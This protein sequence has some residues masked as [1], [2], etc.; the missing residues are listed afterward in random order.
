M[1]PV[2]LEEAVIVNP[3][4]RDDVADGIASA[5]TMSQ[6]ERRDRHA[7]M[8]DVLRKNDITAWRRRF[9]GALAGD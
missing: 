3:H 5:L 9:V 4:D 8:L 1:Q 6:A 2:E 7:A